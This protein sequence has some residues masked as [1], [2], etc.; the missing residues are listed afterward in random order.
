MKQT[1]KKNKKQRLWIVT[2]LFHPDELATSYIL[3]HIANALADRYEVHAI[4]GPVIASGNSLPLHNDIRI[5]RTTIANISKNHII[6]RIFRFLILTTLM[7]MRVIFHCRRSDKVLCVTNPAPIILIIQ[8]IKRI[9]GFHLTILVHD[10]FPENTIP[11]GLCHSDQTWNYRLMKKAY[12]F[13]Y[14]S[15]DKIIVLGEDMK[16][17]LEKK[18]CNHHS[19][20]QICIIPNWADI[21]EVKPIPRVSTD[22]TISLQYAGNLGRVQGLE[23]ILRL[24]KEAHNP[25]LKLSIWG[26]G[27]IEDQLKEY[28]SQEH[29]DNVIFH[30]SYL[31]SKQTEVIG[32]SDL[33]IITLEKG[34]YGLGVP[35]K[36]YNIMAAGRPI[37]FIGPVESEIALEVKRH[38]LG[39]VFSNDDEEGICQFFRSLSANRLPE[40]Q[41]MGNRA[42]RLAEE[43]YSRE[44]VIK[45]Y[46]KFIN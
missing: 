28:C 21:H 22:N 19:K 34:M 2:E 10:V 1:D 6:S 33:S 23:T 32:S 4:C 31:R 25:A 18:I 39:F 45:Q 38:Q 41:E 12:D 17:V 16:K 20:A 15:A 24:F 14:A 43:K 3:T 30:G 46:F 37:L 9:I 7:S 11:A 35:S 26:S 8:M 40:L 13:S 5:H 36:S 42:R 29:L 44:E 27:A